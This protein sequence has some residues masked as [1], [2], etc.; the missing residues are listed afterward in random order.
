[1]WSQ[2]SVRP[3]SPLRALMSV[4]ELELRSRNDRLVRFWFVGV[5]PPRNRGQWRRRAEVSRWPSICMEWEERAC[6]LVVA[7]RTALAIAPFSF[8]L[9]NSPRS[10]TGK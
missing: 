5:R 7:P 8:W 3:M 2:R 1:M 6:L 4:T 10:H 9:L